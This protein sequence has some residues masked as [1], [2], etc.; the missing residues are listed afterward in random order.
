MLHQCADPLCT[1]ESAVAADAC[2]RFPPGLFERSYEREHDPLVWHH[3]CMGKEED[4][5]MITTLAAKD[6]WQNPN[7]KF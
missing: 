6:T 3:A 4:C 7:G 1:A 5:R 2:Q